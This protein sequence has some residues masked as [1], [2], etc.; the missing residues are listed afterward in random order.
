MKT[1]P[2]YTIV[3]VVI[4]QFCLTD[5]ISSKKAVSS[6]S[7]LSS[8]TIS[9]GRSANSSYASANYPTELSDYLKSFSCLEVKGND[10][11]GEVRIKGMGQITANKGPLFVI[12]DL[13]MGHELSRVAQVIDITQIAKV[14]VLRHPAELSIYGQAAQNGVILIELLN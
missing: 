3:I 11:F 2:I 1:A 13:R 5:C 9:S 10:V 14:R 4:L 8:Q 6:S 7:V 12:D